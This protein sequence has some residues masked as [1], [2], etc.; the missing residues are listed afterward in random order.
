MSD[1]EE[2]SLY[3]LE[4]L[5][6]LAGVSISTVSRALNDSSLVSE[7]TKKKILALAQSN[8]YSGKL[9]E[10]VYTEEAEKTISII[11]P[12]PQGRDTRLSDPFILDLIGGIGDALKERNCDLLISHLTLTDYHSA[13]NLVASGRCDGLIVIGQ[14]TLHKQLNQLADIR[15]PF[16]AWGAQLPDQS[17]CSVGSDN[18]QGGRRATRHLIRMGRKRIAFVGETDAPEVALRFKGYQE[19]LEEAGIELDQ[20]LIRPTNFYPESA[21]EAVEE[22]RELGIEFDGVVAASDMI[23]IGAMRGLIRSGVRVPED[24]SVI[25]YDDILAAGFS[26]PALS[27]IKQDV[28]KAGRLMVSK[29]LRLLEGETVQPSILPTDLIIRESCGS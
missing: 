29:L 18:Q 21:M 20:R 8:N 25:G 7:R 16:V 23:A 5:A 12:P 27:T 17:Y 3:R 28:T 9:K 22:M 13:A 2:E 26:S 1:N 14:S 11:I 19:A 15:V 10:K 6:E 24:V 4:D